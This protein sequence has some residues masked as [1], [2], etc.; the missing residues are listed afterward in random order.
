MPRAYKASNKRLIQRSAS[1]QFR[2]STLADFGMGYCESCGAI[3]SPDLSQFNSGFIDPFE[4]RKAMD[5]CTHC[6]HVRGGSA[7]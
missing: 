3:Y 2:R 4:M 6:G 5:T 1:G 7:L